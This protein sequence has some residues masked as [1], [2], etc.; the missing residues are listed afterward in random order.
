MPCLSGWVFQQF[1]HCQ[2]VSAEHTGPGAWMCFGNVTE[3]CLLIVLP[4]WVKKEAAR[5]SAE[6]EDG[7]GGDGGLKTGKV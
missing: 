4:L 1:V 7:I 2:E 3:V 6:S 5:L